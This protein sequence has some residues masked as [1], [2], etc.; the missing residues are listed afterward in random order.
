MIF[1][2]SKSDYIKTEQG[3]DFA[4]SD[5]ERLQM[6]RTI[7]E[8]NPWMAVSDSEL[9]LDHQPRTY[10]TLCSL[11]TDD[12]LLRLL[13]GSDKLMELE[14]GWLH[15]LEICQEFGI[16]VMVRGNDPVEQMIDSD[17]FLSSLKQY[18]TVIHTPDT[19][20]NISS[21]AVRRAFEE[22]R[23]D[24]VSEMIPDGLNLENYRRQK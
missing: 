8:L 24:T 3:K 2:P 23:L 6:L 22:N 9:K 14:H 10:D 17:P 20:Q 1:I 19:W 4:F 13:L 18:F 7:A 21:T 16:A 12:L 5:S 15:V 11:R